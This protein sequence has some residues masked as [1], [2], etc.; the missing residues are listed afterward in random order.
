[1]GPANSAQARVEAPDSL[2]AK[3]GSGIISLLLLHLIPT[4]L[5]IAV[6]R[7]MPQLSG[8]IAI[9]AISDSYHDLSVCSCL[10]R[11]AISGPNRGRPPENK[12]RDDFSLDIP[13]EQIFIIHPPANPFGLCRGALPSSNDPAGLS[14]SGCV[15]LEIVDVSETTNPL[16]IWGR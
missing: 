15:A 8:M 7:M 6:T 3:Y 16:Q 4:M 9:H 2:R 1:M 11:A 14:S 12:Y 5:C 13:S 10:S